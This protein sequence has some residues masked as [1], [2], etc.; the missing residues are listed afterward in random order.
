[1]VND[2]NFVRQI[3]RNNLDNFHDKIILSSQKE[4]QGDSQKALLRNKE[5]KKFVHCCELDGCINST[6]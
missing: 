5:G 1:M 2:G 4:T 3:K 6:N